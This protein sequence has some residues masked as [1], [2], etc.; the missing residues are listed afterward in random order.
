MSIRG[1]FLKFLFSWLLS[2]F[3]ITIFAADDT[4][5]GD[6]YG[7][8]EQKRAERLFYGLIETNG[9]AVNC[10]AC[11]NL[12]YIDTLNWNPS[13]YEIALTYADR[14]SSEFAEILL[15]PLGNKLEEVHAGIDLSQED[16]H[17]LQMYLKDIKERGLAEK[18]PT[19]NKLLKFIGLTLLILLA[20][21]DLLFT[22]KIKLKVVH[23]IVL[24]VAVF[25][26]VE[27]VANEAISL[28]RS[29]NYAPLQPIKFSH[30]VHATDNQID[31][32]YC[33]HTADKSKASGIPSVNVCMNC[34]MIVREGTYSGKFEINKI[35]EASDSARHI[36]WV[37]IHKLP[38][39]V[40]F[41]HAQHVGSGKLDCAECHG[42]VEEMDVVRQVNDLSMGWCLDCHR[43]RKV[44][45]IDNEYYNTFEDF[46]NELIA[47]TID[48]VTV[49]QI[50]GT[51]CMKCHY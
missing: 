12:N 16:I 24:G 39:H 43:T 42:V 9:E 2:F 35:I 14:D 27:L 17:L 44:Q 48:S 4:H 18:K 20:I 7:Y 31:C 34:H 37:R 41:S 23:L 33:H 19:I 32:Q 29:Q 11:H 38:D 13:A 1:R 47:G 8:K 50:G 6:S 36:E 10:A 46:H 15:D 21:I 22:K 26:H 49:E 28:G 51:E 3:F 45:F 25:F 30:K 40:F 5:N